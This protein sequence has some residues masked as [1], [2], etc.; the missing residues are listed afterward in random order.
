M[1]CKNVKNNFI[2]FLENELPEERRVEM[3]KHLKNCPD[4]SRRLGEFSPLWGALKHRERIQ[5][6]PHFWTNLNQRIIDYEE[7]RKSALGWLMGLVRWARPA[8]AVTVLM[9]C[10]FLGYSLGN[11]PPTNGQTVSQLDERTVALQ[12]FFDSHDLDPL[13]D[14]PRGSIEATYLEMV[15][16]E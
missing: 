13:T 9:I 4:C 6:S 15:S 10:V 11:S 2:S 8:V 5:P 12:Q 16:G 7:G 1:N 14:L 3:E